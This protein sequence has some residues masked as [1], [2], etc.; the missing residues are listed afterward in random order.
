MVFSAGKV[1]LNVQ[2]HYGSMFFLAHNSLNG[3]LIH[4][5]TIV[6]SSEQLCVRSPV[7]SRNLNTCFLGI[8]NCVLGVNVH[9][10]GCLRVF[11]PVMSWRLVSPKGGWDVPVPA[12]TQMWLKL[13]KMDGFQKQ[14]K[15]RFIHL[16]V[17]PFLLTDVFS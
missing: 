3:F 11:G 6:L 1:F 13:D 9:V 15:V 2:I 7:S 4:S 16:C 10:N 14:H 8:D 12:L 5:L 17:I